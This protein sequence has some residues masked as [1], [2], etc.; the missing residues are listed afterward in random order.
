M[1][2]RSNLEITDADWTN[3][4]NGETAIVIGNGLSLNDVPRELLEKYPSFGTNHI[5][6]M[7]FQPTYYVCVDT[8]VLENWA[9]EI[10]NT[11][12]R[13][14]IAFLSDEFFGSPAKSTRLLYELPNAYLC[15]K[16]T[17]RF[18]GEYWWTGGT[19]TYVS[20]KIAFGMGFRVV[21]MVGCDRDD[22]WVHFSNEYPGGVT[23]MSYRKDQ[24]YHLG[25]ARLVYDDAGRRIVNLSPPSDLDEYLERGEIEEWT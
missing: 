7:R 23:P 12:A 25:I 1:L 14:E 18:P 24:A 20:L 21:L 5:Y 16:N 3:K 19:S 11:V 4:H 8:R 13:A 10:H 9:K 17:V 2:T 6:L 22:G 15:N